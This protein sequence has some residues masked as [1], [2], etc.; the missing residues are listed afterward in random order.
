MASDTK[1][2]ILAFFSRFDIRMIKEQLD[3]NS[4]TEKRDYFSVGDSA[5]LDAL[6]DT[7][8]LGYLPSGPNVNV[9]V[10]IPAK[11]EERFIAKTLKALAFQKGIGGKPIDF[12]QFEVVVLCHQCI[13]RTVDVCLEMV[14]EYPWLNLMVV[15]SDHPEINNVGG[16]RRVLMR[17][18]T[19]RISDP[20]GYIATTDA[21]TLAGPYWIANILS[22]RESGYGMVCG[23]I[24]VDVAGLTEPE[25]RMLGLKQEY[26]R[27]R[28]ALEDRVLPCEYD[29]A[30]RHSDHSG[31]NLAVRADVYREVGGM[32]A[33]GF[34]EDVAF[35]DSVVYHGH[36]VRH[37]P[38]TMVRTS[39]RTDV[40]A[41]WGF[42]A[43]LSTWKDAREA[44]YAVEHPEGLLNRL[45][46][47]GLT[48]K[49]YHL[50]NGTVLKD[51]IELS[52]LPSHE[53]TPYF[54]DYITD[55]AV[56]HRLEKELDRSENWG[57]RFPKIPVALACVRL[58]NYLDSGSLD[59]CQS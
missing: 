28:T 54:D 44:S 12:D 35:Y 38:L 13:D 58:R 9:V 5:Q 25:K 16:V 15:E 55:K 41:P 33:L 59:F 29:P 19:R 7:L 45:K 51:I 56:M 6:A 4:E 24:E 17:M 11:N 10:T 20:S 43:E 49:Y 27:L 1:R 40:R 23:A 52:G 22:Y 50:R 57:K 42:G 2:S 26:G 30:P 46:I 8:L 36:K 39:G 32:P 48:S 31:P 3:I 53:V 14:S 34:C 21:D 47:F 37:C 18:A